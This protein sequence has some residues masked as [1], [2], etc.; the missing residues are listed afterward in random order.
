MS[1][2]NT[3]V[4]LLSAGGLV[5]SLPASAVLK[6]G[7]SAIKVGGVYVVPNDASLKIG[8]NKSDLSTIKTKEDTNPFTLGLD[9]LFMATNEVGINFGTVWPATVKQKAIDATDATAK[10]EYE[11]WPWHAT[12][13]YYFMTPQDDFRPYVGVG[14][15]YTKLSDYKINHQDIPDFDIDDEF[16]VLFQ[17]GGVYTI[18]ESLFVDFSARYFYLEP[19]GKIHIHDFGKF[20][21]KDMDINP[22]VFNVSVGMKF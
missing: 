2:K 21:V 9:L 11:Y 14:L 13:Q 17:F 12:V 7:E 6:E 20:K 19:K 22:W 3:L 18:D 5:G 16:G 15:H 4:A 1:Y 10:L 8:E